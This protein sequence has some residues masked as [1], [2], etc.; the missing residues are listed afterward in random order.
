MCAPITAGLCYSASFFL[1]KAHKCHIGAAFSCAM[2]NYGIS[3]GK[4]EPTSTLMKTVE[5]KFLG[6][7]LYLMN[8]QPK[9]YINIYIFF[10]DE[11]IMV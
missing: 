5:S 6:I 7:V 1:D 3:C 10:L 4:D 9:K 8:I 2:S 11:V